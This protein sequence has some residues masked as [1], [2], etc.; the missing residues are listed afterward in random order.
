[1][2]ELVFKK[3][4][5]GYEF[6]LKSSIGILERYFV[7]LREEKPIVRGFFKK[8]GRK[9]CET[10]NLNKFPSFWIKQKVI[11]ISKKWFILEEYV[12]INKIQN[13]GFR[14][15]VEPN[16]SLQKI[17]LLKISNLPGKLK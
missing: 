5:P 6:T 17:F 7:S 1:M 15:F 16:D 4:N 2:V 11:Q 14:A 9:F 3:Y 8:T 12:K 13:A 10:L